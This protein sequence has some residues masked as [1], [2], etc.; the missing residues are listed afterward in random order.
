MMEPSPRPAFG[1]STSNTHGLTDSEA[2]ERCARGLVNRV[3]RRTA[4][5]YARIV[6]RNLFTWFNAMVTPAAVALF[7]LDKPQAGIAVS[8]MAIVNTL[9]SLVQEIRAK[10]QLDKLALLV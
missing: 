8:G 6:A 4:R 5:D 2:A 3:P 1:E 9:L 10:Y 7:V